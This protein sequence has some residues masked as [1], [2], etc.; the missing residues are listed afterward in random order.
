MFNPLDSSSVQSAYGGTRFSGGQKEEQDAM[1]DLGD[2]FLMGA[3]GVRAAEGAA[4]ARV[5]AAERAHQYRQ[6]Q[7]KMSTG[8]KVASGI[9]TAASAIGAVGSVVGIAAAI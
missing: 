5:K 6:R 3:M 2:N 4:R 1:A 8:Q 9:G 7:S